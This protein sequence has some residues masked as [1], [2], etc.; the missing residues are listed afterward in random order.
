MSA[1]ICLDCEYSGKVVHTVICLRNEVPGSCTYQPIITR[2]ALCG[3]CIHSDNCLHSHGLM[4][5]KFFKSE[6]ITPM[7]G[8]KRLHFKTK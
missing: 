2:A 8:W 4:W 5:C 3:Q 6:Y 7:S 1:A